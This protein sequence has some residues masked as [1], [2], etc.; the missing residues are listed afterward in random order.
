MSVHVIIMRG[1]PGAGKSFLAKE[2]KDEAIVCSTDKY[3]V[4]STSV[5]TVDEYKFEAERLPQAHAWCF[6]QF[7]L[8]IKSAKK[9]RG[10]KTIIVDNTNIRLWEFQNYELAA[11]MLGARVSIVEVMPK[12]L[13]GIKKCAS[14]NCHGVPPAIV[15]KMALD[16]EPSPNATRMGIDE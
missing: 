9:G 4:H 3:F 7:L 6:N 2:Y 13:V 15:A 5:A 1:I 12:T 11:K 16:F 14:R 8:A 10:P